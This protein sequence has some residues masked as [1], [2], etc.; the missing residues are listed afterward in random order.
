M[1]RITRGVLEVLLAHPGGPLFRNKDDGHWTIPKGEYEADEDALAA[2]Q[3]E[4]AEET[5]VQPPHARESYIDLGEITQKGGTIVRAW[6]FEGDCDAAKLV[7]NTFEMQWPPN[8]GRMQ[9]FPEVDRCEFFT[10]VLAAR[11]IKESQRPLLI[12]LER[13]VSAT[14]R[15]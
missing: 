2:A 6:A 14:A 4:F 10:I 7:S 13:Q 9:S 5:S 1:Y 12:N 11:K 15:P 3:R 8:S